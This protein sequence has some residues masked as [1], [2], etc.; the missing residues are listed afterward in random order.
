MHSLTLPN[1]TASPAQVTAQLFR[2][3]GSQL[4]SQTTHTVP[5]RGY[6]AQPRARLARGR[7]GGRV[8]EAAERSGHVLRLCLCGGRGHR[9]SGPQGG[10]AQ[11]FDRPHLSP[12]RGRQARWRCRGQMGERRRRAERVRLGAIRRGPSAVARPEQLLLV[13]SG[14]YGQRIPAMLP[15]DA[16]FGG[17]GGYLMMASQ[18]ADLRASVGLVNP[19]QTPV[20]VEVR[21]PGLGGQPGRRGARLHLGRRPAGRRSV[22]RGHEPGGAAGGRVARGLRSATRPR[23]T[24]VTMEVRVAWPSRAVAVPGEARCRPGP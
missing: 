5:A 7:R 11:P 13:P 22:L 3:D 9:G 20:E 2:T 24:G 1:P 14:T 21:V 19:P 16:A 18:G 23:R 4:G 6:A 12:S 17:I 10:A 8:G 15:E